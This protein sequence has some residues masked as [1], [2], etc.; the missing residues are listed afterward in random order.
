MISALTNRASLRATGAMHAA[1]REVDTSIERLATGRRINR[2]QD[3]P[4]GLMAAQGFKG[5]IKEIDAQLRAMD[6]DEAQL[7]A[8]EGAV[9]AISDLMVQLKGLVVTGANASGLSPDERAALQ[10]QV[11][12]LLTAV[13]H[14]ANTTT[15]KGVALI[16]GFTTVALGAGAAHDADGRPY[17]LADLRSGGRL[18]MTSTD[19]ASA[20]KV[21]SAA[22]TFAST[23]RASVGA[24]LQG[25]D[26]IR[27][28]MQTELQNIDSARSLIEDTDYAQETAKLVRAQTLQEAAR[29]MSIYAQDQRAQTVLELVRGVTGRPRA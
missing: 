16:S 27:A 7:G 2:A 3:D 8:R 26:A 14:L 24:R 17:T 1:A 5:R 6:Q 29:T 12:G 21:V 23:D 15:F 18:S 19:L 9:S 28:S 25:M 20:E 4:A 10:V 22:A 11:D 13:D